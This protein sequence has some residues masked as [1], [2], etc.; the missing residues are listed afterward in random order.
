MEVHNKGHRLFQAREILEVLTKT[1][2]RQM[3]ATFYLPQ[4]HAQLI[5]PH[6]IVGKQA[7]NSS[8]VVHEVEW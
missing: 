5:P 7:L 3:S 4:V 1:M 8:T 6:V 2:A